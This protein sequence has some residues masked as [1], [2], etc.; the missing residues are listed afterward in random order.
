MKAL[1]SREEGGE[2]WCVGRVVNRN[3]KVQRPR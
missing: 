1:D 2:I 3:G